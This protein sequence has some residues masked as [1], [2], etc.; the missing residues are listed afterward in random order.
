MEKFSKDEIAF[1]EQF[2]HNFSCAIDSDYVRGVALS[3][4]ERMRT[5][6]E[7]ISGIKDFYLNSS[8]GSC[9]LTFFKQIGGEYRKQKAEPTPA[10]AKKAS[11]K[12]K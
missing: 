4:L 8:C 12:K 9:V 10:P 11:P 5:I 1:L 2:E 3:D 6:W 7:R